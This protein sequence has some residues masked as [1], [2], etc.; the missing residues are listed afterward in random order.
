MQAVERVVHALVQ[1]AAS[2]QV[3][4]EPLVAVGR[5]HHAGGIA[6]IALHK[7]RCELGKTL[8]LLRGAGLDKLRVVPVRIDDE[9]LAVLIED[10]GVDAADDVVKAVADLGGQTV[11]AVIV[12]F[13]HVEGDAGLHHMLRPELHAVEQNTEGAGDHDLHR[14]VKAAEVK[15]L[16]LHVPG[17]DA[18][19]EHG[20]GKAAHVEGRLEILRLG[21]GDGAE[22]VAAAAQRVDRAARASAAFAG[23]ADAV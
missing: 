14:A 5:V 4:L 18:P 2:E 21:D 6:Q 22:L 3:G 8:Q 7:A 23:V 19:G 12:V 1:I 11:I 20:P 9:H 13:Q 10:H 15:G 17:L 16:A